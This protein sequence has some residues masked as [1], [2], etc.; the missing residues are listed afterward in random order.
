GVDTDPAPPA[1]D[2]GAIHLVPEAFG[3]E[4]ILSDDR[5]P[6][7]HRR[8]VREGAFDHALYGHGTRVHFAHADETGVRFHP[9]DQCILTAIALEFDIRL[10]EIDRLNFR[11]LH[12]RLMVSR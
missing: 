4:G 3:L 8:C 6:K 1:V 2:I 7:S 10:A 11:D 5:L 9:H 12:K